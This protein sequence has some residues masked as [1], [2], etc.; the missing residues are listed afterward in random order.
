M[1]WKEI[2]LKNGVEQVIFLGLPVQEIALQ[3]GAKQLLELG[4]TL[5]D[6]A[7]QVGRISQNVPAGSIGR[8]QGTHQTA[9]YGSTTRQHGALNNCRLKQESN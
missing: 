9:Q 7:S 4:L 5:D 8:G 6:I 1:K 3:V 2:S